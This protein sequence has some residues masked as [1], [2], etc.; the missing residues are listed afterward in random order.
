MPRQSIVERNISHCSCPGRTPGALHAESS[1]GRTPIGSHVECDHIGD[2]CSRLATV[3]D[4]TLL[5]EMRL[6][7]RR[8]RVI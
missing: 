7:V 2:W 8:V 1:G 3:G 5:D 6:S 4:L